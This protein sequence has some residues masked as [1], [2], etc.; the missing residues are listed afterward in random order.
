MQTYLRSVLMVLVS[1]IITNTI[2]ANTTPIYSLQLT[3]L[4]SNTVSISSKLISTSN[5]TFELQ[6]SIDGKVFNTVAILF[7]ATPDDNISTPI[8]VK[9]KTNVTVTK[10]IYYRLKVANASK[11]TYIATTAITLK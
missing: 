9:D 8:I 10:T 7:A 2:T 1:L 6:K 5:Q 11:E 3:Q 4:N